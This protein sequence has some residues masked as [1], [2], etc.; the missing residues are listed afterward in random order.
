MSNKETSPFDG[1]FVSRHS[2]CISTNEILKIMDAYK[3]WHE[4]Q[5]DQPEVYQVSREW[6]PIYQQYL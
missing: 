2:E 4:I 1:A 6:L 3:D 5:A